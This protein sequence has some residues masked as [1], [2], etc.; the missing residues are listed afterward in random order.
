[1]SF[2][3]A[4]N[5]LLRERSR[6]DGPAPTFRTPTA[7]LGPPRVELDRALRLAA[8]LED[9]DLVVRARRES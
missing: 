2:K 7:S 6:L 1:V 5:G 9:D 4:L 3:E 8:T